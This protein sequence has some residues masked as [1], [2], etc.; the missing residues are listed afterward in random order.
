[1]QVVLAGVAVAH[2]QIVELREGLYPMLVV[3]RLRTRWSI[4]RAS[5]ETATVEEVRAAQKYTAES[6]ERAAPAEDAPKR[7]ATPTGAPVFHRFMDVPEDERADWFWVADR[8]LAEAWF[9]LHAV[10]GQELKPT[11]PRP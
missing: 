10:H 3:V 11:G 1:V 7:P 6:A 4:L 2:G 9:A 8:E 5:F